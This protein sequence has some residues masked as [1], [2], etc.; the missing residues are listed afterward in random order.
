M[1]RM[2]TFALADGIDRPPSRARRSRLIELGASSA[3]AEEAPAELTIALSE[4]LGAE[5][6]SK[7]LLKAEKRDSLLHGGL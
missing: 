1:S 4:N 2:D 5:C 6:L 7:H 3:S